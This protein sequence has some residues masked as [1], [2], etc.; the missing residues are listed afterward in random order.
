MAKS[1]GYPDVGATAV[2]GEEAHQPMLPEKGRASQSNEESV[3]RAWRTSARKRIGVL[4]F[5]PF[6]VGIPLQLGIIAFLG[7]LW[8]QQNPNGGDMVAEH[9]VWR[10]IVMSG[11]TAPAVTLSAVVIR[12]AVGLQLVVEKA[13]SRQ[14]SID[15][16]LALCM[17]GGMGFQQFVLIN[18]R[19]GNFTSWYNMLGGHFERTSYENGWAYYNLVPIR[20]TKREEGLEMTASVC[21]LKWNHTV[22]AIL[23]STTNRTAEFAPKRKNNTA[24]WE[25]EPLLKQLGIIDE[26]RSPD[27]RGFLRL[28]SHTPS[29]EL[30]VLI[31]SPIAPRIIPELTSTAMS[32]FFN[33]G[34]LDPTG[35]VN[36]RDDPLWRRT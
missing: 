9:R 24:S 32:E 1:G 14:T 26:S 15:L 31:D 10:T 23:A 35:A 34:I 16:V 7:Y 2:V 20:G 21:G 5:L 4:G 36:A 3:R 33:R 19:R 30:Q 17:I 22:E 28:H 12:T 29:P 11:W 8:Y 6:L 27:D 25:T 13:K 18:I